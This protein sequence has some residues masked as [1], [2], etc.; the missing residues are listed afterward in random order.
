MRDY[1]ADLR[2]PNITSTDLGGRVTQ[3]QSYLYQLVQDLNYI[4]TQ[5]EE[6][7]SG[8]NA[9]V[10]TAGGSAPVDVDR[11][12][13]QIKLLILRNEDIANSYYNIYKPTLDETY[14]QYNTWAEWVR[15]NGGNTEYLEERVSDLEACCAEVNTALTALGGR[16]TDLETAVAAITSISS[17]DITEIVNTIV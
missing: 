17:A 4:L 10:A 3:I 7:Y 6:E 9:T 14:L 12:F 5:L 1:T 2:F 16:V 8:A 11:L 15:Q 13:S